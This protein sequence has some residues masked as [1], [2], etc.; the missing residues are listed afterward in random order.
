[1]ETTCSHYTRA[2][3][4]TL[5]KANTARD[6]A[7]TR[8]AV[9]AFPLFEAILDRRL[10]HNQCDARVYATRV[11]VYPVRALPGPGAR[12]AEIAG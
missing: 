4:F 8:S 3:L 9:G 11:V 7:C 2:T 1:M 10:Y 6:T 5:D 12:R